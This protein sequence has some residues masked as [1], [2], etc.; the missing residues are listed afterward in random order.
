MLEQSKAAEKTSKF[1]ARDLFQSQ[2]LKGWYI[3]IYF[4]LLAHY[5]QLKL[6]SGKNAHAWDSMDFT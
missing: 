5:L 6:L 3:L 4:T 1:K 2:D